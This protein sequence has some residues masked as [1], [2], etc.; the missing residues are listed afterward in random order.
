MEYL[1]LAGIAFGACGAVMGLMYGTSKWSMITKVTALVMPMIAIIAMLVFWLGSAGMTI[2]SVGIVLTVG[3]P[4]I[5]GLFLLLKKVVVTPFEQQRIEIEDQAGYLDDQLSKIS[6]VMESIAIRGDLEH[7]LKAERD[8]QVGKLVNSINI[9][10]GSLQ[11]VASLAETI[12]NGDLTVEV[13]PRSE[14][15]VLLNTFSKMVGGLGD[16]ISN[17]SE[18]VTLLHTASSDLSTSADQA[19]NATQQVSVASQEMAKGASEQASSTN[20]TVRAVEDLSKILEQI[21][22]GSQEQASGVQRASSAITEVT[23]AI[24]HLSQN[25]ASAAD[26]SKHS[27][28]AA[29]NGA[30]LTRNTVEGM[31]TIKRSVE[32]ASSKVSELGQRSAEIGKIIAVIDDI[33]AQTNLLALN[34]AIEAARAGEQGR[35]F[36]VVSDEVRKLAERTARATKEIADLIANVQGGVEESIKAMQNGTN[37]VNEGYKLAAESG[38]ALEKILGVSA[39][40]SEQL[41]RISHRAQEVST[42]SNDL[43]KIMEDVGA[44]TE[45]NASATE[46]M[47][48]NANQVTR[49]M[50]AVAAVIEEN[51]ASVQEVSAHTQEISAQVTEIATSSQSLEQMSRELQQTVAAFHINDT[52]T[53]SPHGQRKTGSPYSEPTKRNNRSLFTTS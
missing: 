53:Q 21:A 23:E 28:E 47:S 15:D 40:V 20:E 7:S 24:D 41:D 9:M 16:M 34:A 48:L 44:V 2:F 31:E 50:D 52:Q 8:D 49:S 29:Q 30:R 1:L 35:G 26:G 37:E 46:N 42:L 19:G 14:K 5:I 33:A 17:L 27:A 25:A 11:E 18:N 3:L 45:E 10:I 13:K 4:S 36:A 43:V 6:A 22:T 32:I 38:E 39:D 51:S 12:T